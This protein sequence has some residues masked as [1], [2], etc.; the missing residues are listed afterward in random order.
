MFEDEF[1]GN[2]CIH[3]NSWWHKQIETQ[4]TGENLLSTEFW[5]TKFDGIFTSLL[6][7][8]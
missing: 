1:K 2:M 8:F 3:T 7:G 4:L 6:Y 5:F